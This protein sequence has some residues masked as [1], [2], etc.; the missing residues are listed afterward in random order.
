MHVTRGATLVKR[1]CFGILT[2]DSI[3]VGYGWHS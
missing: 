3:H 2:I 1:T